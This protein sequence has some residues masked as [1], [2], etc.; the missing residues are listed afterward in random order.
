MRWLENRL[1]GLRY[2]YIQEGE[3][4]L[5]D[6]AGNMGCRGKT[7][8]VIVILLYWQL[9]SLRMPRSIAG[10]VS[11]LSTTSRASRLSHATTIRSVASLTGTLQT[12]TGLS[13]PILPDAF[14]T[15]VQRGSVIAATYSIVSLINIETV[16]HV[17]LLLSIITHPYLFGMNR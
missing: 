4:E 5:I 1:L 14:I 12:K 2:I 7:P 10:S 6:V 16:H 11:A 17:I 9:I 15:N 3:K 8:N 13:I